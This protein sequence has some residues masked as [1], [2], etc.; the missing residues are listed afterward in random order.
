MTGGGLFNK[1]GKQYN[2]GE[3]IFCEFEPGNSFYLIQTGRVKISKVVKDKEKTMDILSVGD[4]FG[5]M[6]ILEEQPRS[7]TATAIEPVTVL[8][9][10]RDN[11]VS[12]M[13]SQPQLSFKLLVVFSKRIYDAKRRLMILLLDDIQ[14]KI[15]DVFLMLAE[16]EPTYAHM[17][18][19][20]F[21]VTM[22]DVA[23]WAGTSVDQV[24]EQLNHWAKVGKVE[25]YSDRIFVR[26][27][28]DFKRIVAQ[29][30]KTEKR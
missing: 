15:S 29:K 30:R 21:P 10:D 8:H 7:A 14:S 28:A 27:L 3:I 13:M 20:S 22:D 23:N 5:E 2:T 4:I 18:E 16:K 11:F 12:M 24:S 17:R 1:F 9:F 25:L 19:V 26:N 6:A